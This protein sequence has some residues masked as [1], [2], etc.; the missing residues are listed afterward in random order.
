MC[1]ALGV[2]SVYDGHNKHYITCSVKQEANKSSDTARFTSCCIVNTAAFAVHVAHVSLGSQRHF[3]YCSNRVHFNETEK[4]VQY[5]C[6]TVNCTFLFLSN[7]FCPSPN[8]ACSWRTIFRLYHTIRHDSPSD[9][10]L[11]FNNNNGDVVRTSA[12][13]RGVNELFSRR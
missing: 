10:T 9:I 13:I 5:T 8:L 4:R 11:H 12:F 3:V 7:N 6:S 1:E 2:H